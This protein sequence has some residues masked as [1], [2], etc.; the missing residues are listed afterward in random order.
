MKR[1]I[2]HIRWNF[3]IW[4]VGSLTTREKQH[5]SRLTFFRVLARRFVCNHGIGDV[6][7]KVVEPAA[8]W[9]RAVRNR[10]RMNDGI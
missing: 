7:M 2:A 3:A 10:L 9:V 4:H 1:N 6:R 8:K 5:S